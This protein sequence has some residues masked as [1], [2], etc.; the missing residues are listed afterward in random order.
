[1]KP[2]VVSKY[3]MM[4]ISLIVFS[5]W[6]QPGWAKCETMELP[7]QPYSSSYLPRADGLLTAKPKNTLNPPKGLTPEQIKVLNSMSLMEKIDAL[8]ASLGRHTHYQQSVEEKLHTPGAPRWAGFCDVWSASSLDPEVN[9]YISNSQKVAVCNNIPITQAEVKEAFTGFYEYQTD[10]KSFRGYDLKNSLSP[11]DETLLTFSGQDVFYGHDLDEVVTK[12][13]KN[14]QGVVLNVVKTKERWNQPVF[15]SHRCEDSAD[16]TLI[17]K[18]L[19]VRRLDS[20]YSEVSEFLRS[21]NESDSNLLYQ[22]STEAYPSPTFEADRLFSSLIDLKNDAK[23]KIKAT[24]DRFV[25]LEGVDR[26]DYVRV[27]KIIAQVIV[28][29]KRTGLVKLKDGLTLT[30]VENTIFYGKEVPFAVDGKLADARTY[31]YGL[32]KNAN[33]QVVDSFWITAPE[34]RPGSIWVP[35]RSKTVYGAPLKDLMFILDLCKEYSNFR[36]KPEA[37]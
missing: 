30:K 24:I 5:H 18:P 31:K 17:E 28:D 8:N 29:L 32:I 10:T 7:F 11:T 6:S 25:Q 19:P 22:F 14:G 36:V 34:E 35:D 1:M 3:V 27:R 15:K 26:R 13:L 37:N 20:E 2:Q 23:P 33:G 21:I 16:K 4:L 12:N 9:E